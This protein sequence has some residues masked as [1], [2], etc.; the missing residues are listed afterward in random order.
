MKKITGKWFLYIPLILA[1]AYLIC[2]ILLYEFGPLEWKTEN[3]AMFWTFLLLYHAAFI[4]GYVLSIKKIRLSKAG[5]NLSQLSQGKFRAIMWAVIGICAVC[6]CIEY[7]NIT[8]ADS[9]IPYDL[10]R[11]FINGLINPAQQYYNKFVPEDYTSNKLVTILSALFSFVYVSLPALLVVEWKRISVPQKLCCFAIVVF[12]VAVYVSVGTNKGIFDT[13]FNFVGIVLILLLLNVFHGTDRHIDKK[14][15]IKVSLF[16]LF[17]VVFSFT[18]FTVNISSRVSSPVDYALSVA[19]QETRPQQTQSADKEKEDHQASHAHRGEE[20]SE[21][22]QSPT[23]ALE[24]LAKALGV[25]PAYLTGWEEEHP[26]TLAAHFEGEEF[27][28]DELREIEAFVR[29]VK[30][31]RDN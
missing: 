26:H 27:S 2:T 4:L 13:M 25:T 10:P 24:K 14:T 19:G 21:E 17:L 31:R 12:K 18:Y 28:E 8:H 9:Y 3:E 15:F 22:A 16:A 30:S 20:E 6:A 11:N 23:E 5:W 1:E 7:K 29:F